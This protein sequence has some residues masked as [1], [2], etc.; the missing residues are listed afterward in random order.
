[1]NK[2]FKWGLKI[3]LLL[4]KALQL[5]CDQP[6]KSIAHMPQNINLE[7]KAGLGKYWTF[8]SLP[9]W[10]QAFWQTPMTLLHYWN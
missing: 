7:L 8:M 2:R 10:L 1:M 3:W 5:E 4:L 9:V 6:H